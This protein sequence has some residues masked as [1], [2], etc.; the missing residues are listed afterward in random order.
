MT[1]S[2]TLATFYQ[3][4]AVDFNLSFWSQIDELTQPM[5]LEVSLVI[6]LAHSASNGKARYVAKNERTWRWYAS[7]PSWRDSDDY[8]SGVKGAS[9]GG[10]WKAARDRVIGV[11]SGTVIDMDDIFHDTH[12]VPHGQSLIRL[13]EA[14]RINLEHRSEEGQL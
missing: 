2:N 6:S 14:N 5:I 4:V 1:N 7:E 10:Y 11:R 8:W 3:Q 13:P 9:E 12:L